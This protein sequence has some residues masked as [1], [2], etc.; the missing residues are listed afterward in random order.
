LLLK[1]LVSSNPST[2]VLVHSVMPQML[3]FLSR[4]EQDLNFLRDHPPPMIPEKS[5]ERITLLFM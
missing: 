2:L 1:V 3:S 5:P 4:K